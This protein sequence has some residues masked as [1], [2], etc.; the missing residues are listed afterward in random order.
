MENKK[1]GYWNVF[2]IIY[3]LTIT[4]INLIFYDK[5]TQI[6]FVKQ[7][8]F[9]LYQLIIF[10]D[11]LLFF[12]LFLFKLKYG[13]FGHLKR[14]KFPEGKIIAEYKTRGRIGFFPIDDIFSKWIIFDNGLGIR[15]F[16]I[17]NIFIP[18]ENFKIF[19]NKK[20]IHDSPEIYNPVKFN[21][22]LL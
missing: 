11:I 3:F 21:Q 6:V 4:V 2:N 18:K 1:T 15:I 13:P 19:D 22:K 17:I 14:N 12:S 7:P 5:I 8:L 20:L 9:F 16:G 10:Y